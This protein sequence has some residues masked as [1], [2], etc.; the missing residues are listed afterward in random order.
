MTDF[1]EKSRINGINA[2]K[3]QRGGYAAMYDDRITTARRK[4]ANKRFV[5]ELME[6][7]IVTPDQRAIVRAYI[8]GRQGDGYTGP[9]TVEVG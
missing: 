6:L 2:T 3:G 1:A 9:L 7:G 8:E 5:M 4:N